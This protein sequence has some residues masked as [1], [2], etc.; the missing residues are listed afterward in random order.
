MIMNNPKAI[1]TIVLRNEDGTKLKVSKLPKAQ[2]V[3]RKKN[4]LTQDEK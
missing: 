3:G 2:K 4:E 1:T